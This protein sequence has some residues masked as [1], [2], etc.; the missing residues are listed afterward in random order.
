MEDC[1]LHPLDPAVVDRY[2]RALTGDGAQALG[3][4][5][6]DPAW[7]AALLARGRDAYRRA[8]E[9][10]EE[11]ANAVSHGLALALATAQPTFA[12]PGLALTTLEARIDRGIGMLIRPPSRLFADAGLPP[13]AAWAMPIRLD[14]ARGTMGGAFVPARLVPDLERLIETR[15]AR[16]LRR[17]AEAELDNVAVLGLLIDACATAR[18]QGFGLY[19]ALDA[20]V[21]DAPEA[22]PPGARVVTADRRRLDPALRGHLEALAKPPKPPGLVARLLGRGADRGASG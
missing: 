17:L 22:D 9:G 15:S 19:E 14:L 18:R 5:T 16:L 21:P 20:V 6:P 10:S 1:S 12:T 13:A 11:G 4:G 8:R 2:V 7:E 3:L